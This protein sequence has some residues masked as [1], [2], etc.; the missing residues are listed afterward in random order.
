MWYQVVSS[1]FA[2]YGGGAREGALMADVP[3]QQWLMDDGIYGAKKSI[4]LI[5]DLSDLRTASR[6]KI[7]M[8]EWTWKKR[9][10]GEL[11]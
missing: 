9:V 3:T 10:G 8:L 11:F 6:P 5:C 1:C 2:G 7:W 4:N